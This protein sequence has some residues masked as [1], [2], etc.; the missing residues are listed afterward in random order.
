MFSW[1]NG[2]DIQMNSQ[3]L[4]QQAQDLHKLQTDKIQN[5]GKGGRHELW[6]A[7]EELLAFGSCWERESA[8]SNNTAPS[9][10]TTYQSIL[11]SQD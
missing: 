11:Y 2:A 6:P 5:S 3:Q 9:M 10:L 4:Q 8:F 7:A 1:Y